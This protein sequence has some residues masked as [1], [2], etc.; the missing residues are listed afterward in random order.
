MRFHKSQRFFEGIFLHHGIG[1]KQE[2]IFSGSFSDSLIIG[3]GETGVGGVDNEFYLWKF[4]PDEGYGAINGIIVNHKHL[5][6][7]VPQGFKNG[8]QALFKEVLDVVIDYNN[9]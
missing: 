5:S 4:L 2:D 7:N 6:L 3:F 8:I 9:G 1:I